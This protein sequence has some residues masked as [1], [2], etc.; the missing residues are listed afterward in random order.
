MYI[1]ASANQ[2]EKLGLKIFH[3]KILSKSVEAKNT[4]R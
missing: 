4:A 2:L 1:G 3:N